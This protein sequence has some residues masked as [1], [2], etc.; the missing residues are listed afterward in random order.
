M[1]RK[2]RQKPLDTEECARIDEAVVDMLQAGAIYKNDA[3]NLVLSPIYTVPKKDSNKRRLVINLRWVNS[4]LMTQHFKMTTIR[5]V[6][7]LVTKD[8]FMTKID[9]K[10]CY[11]QVPV[12]P[13]HQ[14]FLSFQWRGQNYSFNC[15]PFG[16]SVSPWFVTKLFRPVIA[17]LQQ[18]GFSL[19][20]YLDDLVIVGKSR[21]D[22]RTATART[23]ELL[24]Q[25]GLI[26]NRE[27]SILEPSQ[28]IEYLGFTLDSVR[29]MVL[30]PKNKLKNVNTEIKKFLNRPRASARHAA[31]VIG[32]IGAL[33]EALFPTRV[34]MAHIQQW[35]SQLLLHGWD[36]EEMTPQAV[37]E[38]LQWWREHLKEMNGVSLLPTSADITAGTDASD[39]GWGAW[40][41]PSNGEKRAFGG[42]F[43]E[44]VLHHHIN[45]KELLAVKFMLLS[46]KQELR[47]KVVRIYTDNI[48]AMYYA[49]RLGGRKFLLT[50]LATE[51]WQILD[52]IKAKIVVE[53][54]PGEDNIVADRESRRT[55]QLSDMQL[56][57]AIF[58]QAEA[59]WGPH[60][61]DLFATTENTHLPRF[62][63]WRPSPEATW[64][65]AMNHSWVKENGW[66]HPPFSLLTK[67]L[68]KVRREGS[69]ITLVAPWWPAQPWFP[70][71]L[72]M[73]VGL[74]L[75]PKATPLLVAPTKA[76]SP[77]WQTLVWRV[78]GNNSKTKVSMTRYLKSLR[79]LGLRAQ[80]ANTSSS[81]KFG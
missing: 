38:D 65:D 80:L 18:E 10:D 77:T 12:L 30:A 40:I 58:K 78:S 81:G 56:N 74:P 50:K 76:A 68:A 1:P 7:Q 39:I 66:A 3:K 2:L 72:D 71:L 47:G 27:K 29:M 60:S 69:T 46:C 15:L 54:V 6:K 36:H 25:L 75:L 44:D 57:P 11:W 79:R 5:E 64:V 34:H 31:S 19:A 9:L 48:T 51:I 21:A 22:C 32:K 67:V 55:L 49:N 61:I 8:A 13:E 23:L 26:V 43:Q 70:L 17:Q 62:A 16:L 28:Q 73:T 4:H 24:S 59:M 52:S 53:F 14:R 63:S 33:S 35:K 41:Q 20:I 37:R 42:F 45:Y